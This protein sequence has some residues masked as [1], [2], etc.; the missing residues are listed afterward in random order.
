M[1]IKE[2]AD[3][4]AKKFNID[5]LA[6]KD[7]KLELE[8]DGAFVRIEETAG[9]VFIVSGL[10]GDTPSEG[11]DVFATIALKG[12][13]ELMY[14]KAC[15]ITRSSE[16]DAY[17]LVERMPIALAS[18]FESFCESLGNFV[19][20]LEMWRTMLSDFDPVH[21]KATSLKAEK[22]AEGIDALRRGFL[23]A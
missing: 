5:G 22:A 6:S 11:D 14:S 20:T 21:T 19:N 17:V 1:S 12:N 8:I 4:I 10:V 3:K 2:I 7:G 23:I 9:D 18:D 15:A 16:T 13:M